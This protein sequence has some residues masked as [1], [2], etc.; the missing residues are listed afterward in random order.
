MLICCH[1]LT[2]STTNLYGRRW[3]DRKLANSTVDERKELMTYKQKTNRVVQVELLSRPMTSKVVYTTFEEPLVAGSYCLT[4]SITFLRA[5]K[6]LNDG[7]ILGTVIIF[8]QSP[9]ATKV[10]YSCQFATKAQP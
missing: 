9:L 8:S 10:D 2:F 3:Y 5:F 7:N 6:S 1:L 4:R